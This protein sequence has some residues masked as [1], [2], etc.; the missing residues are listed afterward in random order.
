MEY[1]PFEPLPPPPSGELKKQLDEQDKKK[2]KAELIKNMK[3]E[4]IKSDYLEQTYYY[5]KVSNMIFRFDN[6]SSVPYPPMSKEIDTHLREINNLPA[7]HPVEAHPS[8]QL[9]QQ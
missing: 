4:L 3:L 2:R 8:V 9:N 6:K 5:Q 1:A 7:A